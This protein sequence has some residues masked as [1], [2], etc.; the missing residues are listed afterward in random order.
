MNTNITKNKPIV[1]IGAG[2]GGLATAIALRQAGFEVE[3][4]E[5][6]NEMKEVGAGLTL[7]PNAVKMLYRLG[8]DEI[9][10]GY[11]VQEMAGGFYNQKGQL[12][13]A[14]STGEIK[15]R[16]GAPGITVHRAEL[17]AALLKKAGPERVHLDEAL[18]RFEQHSGGVRAF[19]ASGRE[20]EGSVLV[21]ADGLHSVVRGQL[22]GF[23]KP[24]YSGY[25]AWRGVVCRP[26]DQLLPG[27]WWGK[28]Q[29]FGIVPLSKGRV[30]WF[31]TKNRPESVAKAGESNR[32]EL[33]DLFK[34][35]HPLVKDLIA[36][37][38]EE[39]ILHNP[40][41][42]RKP[43][44]SWSVGRV[45]LLG[46]AAHPMTPNM[47]QGACQALEDAVALAE[48]LSRNEDIPA[49]LGRY[50]EERLAHTSLVV[51]RSW[52]IGRVAQ[53]ANPLACW[54]RNTA[55]KLIPAEMQ[56]R[57]LEPVVGHQV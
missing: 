43:L 32:Q 1:I 37:T 25:T 13:A 2:I 18:V 8:L 57:Q 54:L 23:D 56:I 16:F 24:R 19:F 11:D 4:F 10:R 22:F 35:W 31:A 6:V 34:D 29:R 48:C 30:Y 17:Q 40:I 39:A 46:D 51:N 20:V 7:W 26:H 36:A 27:E 44:K 28:G 47:G 12:L 33:R 38:P 49:A 14:T 42:D 45:T 50:Q 55:V 3:I 53:W 52:Q 21:G 5:R 9:V 41:Y 15:A